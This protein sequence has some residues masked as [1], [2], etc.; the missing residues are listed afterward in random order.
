MWT[1]EEAENYWKSIIV[2]KNKEIER[3][4]DGIDNVI[5]SLAN[6]DTSSEHVV[7]QIHKELVELYKSGEEK[8]SWLNGF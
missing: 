6:E 2:D 4:L 7:H 8:K 3:L 5:F 1:Q